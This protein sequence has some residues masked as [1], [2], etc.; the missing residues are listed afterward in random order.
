M[1]LH[2]CCLFSR[3]AHACVQW[4]QHDRLPH[5]SLILTSHASTCSGRSRATHARLLAT[6]A[7]AAAALEPLTSMHYKKTMRGILSTVSRHSH[8][9]LYKLPSASIHH[10][11]FSEKSTWFVARPCLLLAH[12]STLLGGKARA[13]F[14]FCTSTQNT[15]LKGLASYTSAEARTQ[16]L[17]GPVGDGLGT[18]APLSR[19]QPH[20]LRRRLC[21]FGRDGHQLPPACS[22]HHHQKPMARWPCLMSQAML[23][24]CGI[25]EHQVRLLGGYYSQ[26]SVLAGVQ[27]M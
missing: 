12:G 18:R 27:P 8:C 25:G 5:E 13:V 1:D 20:A 2:A 24:Q 14:S 7:S 17:E 26:Q 10:I 9:R 16:V 3:A 23:S 11:R 4:R 21:C 19:Q 15:S 22:L 6:A